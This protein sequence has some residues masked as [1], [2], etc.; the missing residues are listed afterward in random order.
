MN[1]ALIGYGKMGRTIEALGK[2]QGRA[3][4]LIID[5]DNS[6]DLSAK[7]LKGIDVAIEFTVPDSAPENIR[8]CIDHG[9]PVVSGTTGWNDQ[10]GEIE[11]YCKKHQ[12]TLFYA[13]NFSI[14]VNILFA[15][16][17]RLARIM[18]NFTS[19]RVSMEE[20]HHIHK[21]D[22]PSG[23]AITLAEQIIGRL[24]LIKR[25]SLKD[26]DNS[27]VVHIDAIREGEVKGR[28]SIRYESDL[29]SL[30]LSHNAKSREAFAAGALLAATFIKEKTGIF[31]M[32]D[33]LKL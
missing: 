24:R 20:V 28:H 12:G 16:N 31:G 17:D 32:K 29:D 1:I 22:A 19:Y 30:T 23:T 13:S 14:G 11:D 10:F 4:P 21:L 3:F 15:L 7:R 2:D 25:W 6:E 33:L 8:T 5:L 9:I 18:N 27:S 26:E